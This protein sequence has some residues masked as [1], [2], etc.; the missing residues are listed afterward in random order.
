L[1]QHVDIEVRRVLV[2]P[3]LQRAH[4]SQ[5]YAQSALS[6]LALE[7]IPPLWLC[8]K[9]VGGGETVGCHRR[10]TGLEVL[11]NVGRASPVACEV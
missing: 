1:L 6:P 4:H 11:R 8:A 5:L 7:H 9:S 2:E 3:L 10:G